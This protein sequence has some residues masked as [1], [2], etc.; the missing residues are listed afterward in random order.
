V[1]LFCDEDFMVFSGALTTDAAHQRFDE[2][3]IRGSELAFA[4][5][6]A[7]WMDA[8]A[9][10]GPELEAGVHSE[11]WV[12][13]LGAEEPRLVADG[14]GR[15]DALTWVADAAGAPPSL[16]SRDRH[17]PSG[18]DMSTTF[19]IPLVA[20]AGAESTRGAIRQCRELAA[21]GAEAILLHVSPYFGAW[22]S[23]GEV[24][25]HYLAVAEASPVPLIA[26]HIPK[27]TRVTLEPGLVA[28][29][30]RLGAREVWLLAVVMFVNRAG[31][32]V[33]PFMTLYLTSQLDMS[34]ALAGRLVM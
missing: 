15:M 29:L 22:L 31:T 34:E 17:E 7:A 33:L 13:H 21:A 19:R 4:K 12:L 1:Q 26:Y 24:R 30:A 25:D 3:L 27:H 11:L 14:V 28:E 16:A 9:A 10:H 23:P 2:M 6:V 32:M 5:Q 20:G 8:E 18:G